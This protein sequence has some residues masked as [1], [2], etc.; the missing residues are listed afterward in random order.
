M[1]RHPS[2]TQESVRTGTVR[3]GGGRPAAPPAL[4]GL[5]EIA[6]PLALSTADAR[7]LSPALFR[8]LRMLDEGTAEYSYVRNTLVEMNLSLVKY[9]AARFRRTSEPLED[10]IQVG[11]V[12]LIKAINRFDPDRGCE[13]TSFALPT[14]LGE[15][16]R[17]FRDATW[18]VRVPRRLQELRIDLAKAGDALEQELGRPATVPEL[19]ERLH[20]TPD[21]VDEGRLAANGFAGH[22]LD[23][24]PGEE[25]EGGGLPDR[26]LGSEDTGFER[27]EDLESL[28]P[29]LTELSERDRT[30]LSLRFGAEL[31]QAEIGARLG[32]SQMHVSRLLARILGQLRTG[33]TGPG[34]HVRT[35]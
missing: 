24:P 4:A 28:K 1:T 27:V 2:S 15:I 10:L 29:L 25:A 26:W 13:F 22:S 35:G 9:A 31:T 33:L 34:A 12:G 19:A 14:V 3:A 30:I 18:A 8:R 32:I 20:V 21:E 5:P 11:T 7:A 17:H 16:K 6:D 23:L